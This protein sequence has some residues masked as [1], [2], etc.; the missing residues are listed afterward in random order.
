MAWVQKLPR[1]SGVHWRAYWRDPSGKIHGKVFDRKRDAERYGRD[2]ELARDSGTYLDPSRGKMSLETYV[3]QEILSSSHRAE[4]TLSNYRGL[5]ESHDGRR[6]EKGT[7]TGKVRAVVMPR[8]VSDSVAMHMRRFTDPLNSQ[9][10]VF[11][12]PQGG[13]VLHGNFR[14]RVFYPACEAAGVNPPPRVQDLRHTAAALAIRRGAGPKQIQEML[15]HSSI[16]VTMDVYG[17][18]FDV[19]HEE[20]ADR[21]DAAIRLLF[22]AKDGTRDL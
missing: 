7:K 18:L 5:W 22:E 3:E 19:L 1:K 10:L 8:F 20:L 21:H 2:Q 14:K 4:K 17:H 16:V 6:L 12:A 15:G 9:G 13:A 11:T